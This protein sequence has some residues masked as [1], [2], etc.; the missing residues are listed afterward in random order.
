VLLGAV[1][2]LA[3]AVIVGPVLAGPSVR[4]F[5]GPVRRRITGRLATENAARS[6]KRTSSTASALIIGVALVALVT[7][8]AESIQRSVSAEFER[9]ISADVFVQPSGSFFGGFGGF[10]PEVAERVAATPGVEAVTTFS[11]DEA[12]VTYPDG[13]TAETFVGAIEPASY[14]ALTTP[15]FVEGGLEDLTPDGVIVD[16]RTR[17]DN[18]LQIGDTVQFR[19]PA[20]N[21]V[22]LTVRAVSDD[23]IVF[24]P[25]WLIHREAYVE[26]FDEVLDFQVFATID[27]GADAQAVIGEIEAAVDEFPSIEVLDREEFEGDLA[28]QLST[29]VNVIYGLLALSVLIAMIGVMNTLALSVHE[30][31][32][33][34]GLLR[35]VGMTRGQLRSSIRWEAL[36]I[37]VLAAAVGLA[38]GLVAAYALVKALEGFGLTTFGVPIPTMAVLVVVVTGAGVLASLLPAR[39]AAK[40]DV[41]EAIARN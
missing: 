28:A 23:P 40:L 14:A 29:F 18:D 31:T 19:L 6:P 34:I 38:V 20:G 41:L 9:G 37:A 27:D 39:R 2:L 17:D 33:E 22:D 30:R 11:G 13:D 15:E 35:A 4:A 32:R 26:H 8:A 3:G 7:V 10:S 5:G 12:A 36:L 1:L 16:V 21:T 24:G 25:P